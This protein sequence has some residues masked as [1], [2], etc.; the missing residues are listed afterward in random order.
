MKV[1]YTSAD[2]RLK[3][4]FEGDDQK[5]LFEQIADFQEVFEEPD[6]GACKSRD[7]RFVARANAG[8]TFYEMHCLGCGAQL[9]FGVNKSGGTL[10]PKRKDDE[11]MMPH[12]G[13]HHWQPTPREEP[14]RPTQRPGRP[15]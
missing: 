2:G 13:W 11:G 3:C 8:N 15:R 6:C 10:F 9:Q 7:I 12:R 4:V 1:E 5:K 14:P